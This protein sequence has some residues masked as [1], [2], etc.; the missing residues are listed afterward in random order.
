M[1][2]QYNFM[3]TMSYVY[4]VATEAASIGSVRVYRAF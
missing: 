2:L 3:I 1:V 4:E